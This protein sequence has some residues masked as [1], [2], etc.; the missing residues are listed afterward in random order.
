[1]DCAGPGDPESAPAALSN[2]SQLNVDEVR[3]VRIQ[4]QSHHPVP[5][6]DVHFDPNP[7]PLGTE[8]DGGVGPQLAPIELIARMPLVVG[9]PIRGF[10][11]EQPDQVVV[12][13][14]RVHHHDEMIAG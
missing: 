8:G 9:V 12:A 11:L 14:D 13:G 6:L 7:R 4:A 5:G 10:V 1:M 2:I 3:S